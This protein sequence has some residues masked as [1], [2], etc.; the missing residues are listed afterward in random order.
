VFNDF[1]PRKNDDKTKRSV[2]NIQPG[3]KPKKETIPENLVMQSTKTLLNED[4]N[5]TKGSQHSP[6]PRHQ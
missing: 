2:A 5:R 4:F 3:I 6:I 1:V